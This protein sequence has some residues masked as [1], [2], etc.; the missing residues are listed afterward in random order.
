M[1][2][3]RMTLPHLSLSTAMKARNCSGV[4]HLRDDADRLEPI[5]GVTGQLAWMGAR[6]TVV[7][8]PLPEAI[9]DLVEPRL[10]ARFVE[11]AAGCTTDTD[12]GN[13]LVADLDAQRARL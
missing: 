9:A 4:S 11:I 12:R 2:A 7:D 6:C 10:G 8:F 5:R 3:A 13:G 1:P